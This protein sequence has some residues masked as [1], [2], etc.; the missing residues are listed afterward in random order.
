MKKN[1]LKN[2]LAVSVVAAM[3][4]S[5][6]ACSD[7][8]TE[9]SA[10]TEAEETV[11]ETTVEE[12]VAETEASETAAETTV[13]ETEAEESAAAI[14]IGDEIDEDLLGSWTLEEDGAVIVYTFNDDN[15][16][17]CE[18]TYGEESVDFDMQYSADGE[19]LTVVMVDYPEDADTA[20][21]SIDGDTLTLVTGD[22]TM[23]LTR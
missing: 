20:E 17:V 8:T 16:G 11:V 18:M 7:E 9:T 1:V 3:A 14:E 23:E 10:E 4:M 2:V 21:Y 15:T 22:E 19:T 6:V 13:A 5:V 12:T